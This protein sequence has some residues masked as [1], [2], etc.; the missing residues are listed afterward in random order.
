MVK[1]R[2]LCLFK[3]KNAKKVNINSNLAEF[4][5]TPQIWPPGCT[6]MWSIGTCTGFSKFVLCFGLSGMFL[7]MLGIFQWVKIVKN[8]YFGHFL[9]KWCLWS[10][11]GLPLCCLY[12]LKLYYTLFKNN[13]DFWWFFMIILVRKPKKVPKFVK[14]RKFKFFLIFKTNYGVD[15]VHEEIQ[16]SYSCSFRCHQT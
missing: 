12:F 10:Y 6:Q 2:G 16:K 15:R 14:M 3:A 5:R 11:K 13:F 4:S 1:N 7:C 8:C 9:K